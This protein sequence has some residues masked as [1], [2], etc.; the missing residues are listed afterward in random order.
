MI[1]HIVVVTSRL[2]E[3]SMLLARMVFCDGKYMKYREL[4]MIRS[5][6]CQCAKKA[7]K[8]MSTIGVVRITC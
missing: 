7:K 2:I 4:V 3:T 8:Y 6:M 1:S 5:L